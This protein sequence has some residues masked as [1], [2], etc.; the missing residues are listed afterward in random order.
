MR[1]CEDHIK[2]HEG[3]AVFDEIFKLIFAK[4]YDERRN[5]K[6]DDSSAQFRVGVFEAAEDAR[7][8]ISHLFFDAKD[9]WKGVF[10]D[11]EEPI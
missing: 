9:Q 6:N 7:V 1:E 5:L 4:L 3:A 11:A 10:E 8:R 2:A